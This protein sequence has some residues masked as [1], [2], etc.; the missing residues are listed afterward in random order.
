MAFDVGAIVGRLELQRDQW[1]QSIKQV[2]DDQKSLSGMVLRNSQQF[3]RMG[4][5]MTIAGTAVVGAVGLMVKS[6]ATFDK[7]MTES[8][9]IMGDISESTRKEMAQTALDMSGKSTF[10]AKELAGAYFF[11]ASAGMDAEQSMKA[12]PAVTRFAQAGT[13]DLAVATDLL[14]DAQTALGLSSKDAVENQE[15]LIRVSDVLVGAN[16]LAN[17]SVQQ[18]A[19]ALTNK[20]AAA[21]RNVNKGMEEGVAILAAYADRGIKGSEAGQLL[22]RMM[23]GLFM[24]TSRNKE[25]WDDIDISLWDATGQMRHTGDI[26]GDLEKHLGDMT[27]EM[28]TA[29]LATLGFTIRTKDSVLSLLGSSEKIKTW[30]EDL[31]NMGGIS[32]EVADKQLQTLVNQFIILKNKIVNA[33]ISVGK[34]LGPA[35]SGMIEKLKGTVGRVAEWI[36]AH[37]KL[38]EVIAKSAVAFGGLLMVLG[39]LMMMLP[40]L[41]AAGPMIGAAFTAMLG[42][43]GLTI[44]GLAVLAG[45]INHVINISKKRADVEMDAMVNTAKGHAGMW[46]LRKQLIDNEIVTVEEWGEIYEK[47]GRNHKRVMIAMAKAPEY[48]FIR[49]ELDKLKKQKEELGESDDDLTEKIRENSEEVIKLTV[50]MVDEI[51]QATLGEFEYRIWAAK[52]TY[53][54]RKAFLEAE[55][56]DKEAFVL[57]ER[58]LAIELDGIEKDRTQKLKDSWEEKGRAIAAAL[59]KWYADE[60]TAREKISELHKGYTNTIMELTLSEKDNKL[61]ILDE[62]YAGELEKLGANLEAKAALEE[63]YGLKKQEIDDETVISQMSMFEKIST[64]AIIALGRSKAGAVAQATMSTYAGAAKTLEMLGM[65]A[66]I[67]FIAM[68]IIQGF[69]QVKSILAVKVPSAERG[70]YL[71]TPALVEAGHGRMGE[72]ILPLDRAQEFFKEITTEKTGGAKIDL[73]FYAPIIST[74]GVSERDMDRAAEYLLNKVQRQFERYGGKMNA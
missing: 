74:T 10:A 56:A 23:N 57:L 6:Y 40:G 20:A 8:L 31:K 49:E 33:A 34:T 27:P 12:L 15:N 2:K 13:F 41:I 53:E 69:K 26:I 19:E 39:P 46:A 22:T 24:A 52:Q 58:T 16:T 55:E 72:V 35:L 60:K 25:A 44:I 37:P 50:D 65:P 18:F 62:W 30:T 36:K 45:W 11:L 64:A 70:A 3:K 1:N 42:P 66:A 47:H 61:R 67:P 38:T 4:R 14:T 48:A 73:N 21:L 71:P 29:E 68:A 28:R 43:I 9:A 51:M 7:A 59:Q 17:A 63:A 5:T 32:K 54:E